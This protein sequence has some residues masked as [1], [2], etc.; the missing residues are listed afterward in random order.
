M[1]RLVEVKGLR[2]MARDSDH[3]RTR[4]VRPRGVGP[5]IRTSWLTPRPSG[6]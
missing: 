2:Q 3:A 4:P 6:G 1:R 5:R